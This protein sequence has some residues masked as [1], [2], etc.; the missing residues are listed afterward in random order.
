MI[1]Y[2]VEQRLLSD[3]PLNRITAFK[4]ELLHYMTFSHSELGSSIAQSGELNDETAASLK[5]A[6]EEFKKGF[7]AAEK[8]DDKK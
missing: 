1:L 4:D 2:S 8:N 5:K 3:V 6:V 7:L